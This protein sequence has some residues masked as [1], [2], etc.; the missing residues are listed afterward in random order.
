MGLAGTATTGLE[1]RCTRESTVGSNPTPSAI[2]TKYFKRIG[3]PVRI[4]TLRESGFSGPV[5]K[6]LANIPSLQIRSLRHNWLLPAS[7]ELIVYRAQAIYK[8]VSYP[9]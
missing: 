8:W 6:H 4:R 2:I 7:N 9:L 3:S 5:C 1:N